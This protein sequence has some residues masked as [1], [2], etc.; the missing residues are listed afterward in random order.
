MAVEAAAR[1][2]A[3]GAQRIDAWVAM[4]RDLDVGPGVHSPSV[5]SAFLA[6][7][8]LDTQDQVVVDAGCG[9]GLVTIAA[10]SS[11]AR[12]VVAQDYDPAAL[13]DTMRNVTRILG[14]KARERLSLWEADWR[15]LGP[16]AADLLAV[17][18]PQRPTALMPDVPHDQRHL[19]DGGG[20][21][22]LDGIRLVLA[23]ANAQRVRTTAAAAL[24]MDTRTCADWSAPRLIA[25]AWLPFAPAWRNLVPDLRGRVGIWEFARE[26]R[27]A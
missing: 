9:A 8:V 7:N 26:P 12:H 22:G 18:P 23:H 25:D 11:G 4:A 5:F 3:A 2:D 14:P 6:A 24:R 17:N 13:N 21:D 27:N 15:Q 20:A 1:D 16:M 19:H 10:L